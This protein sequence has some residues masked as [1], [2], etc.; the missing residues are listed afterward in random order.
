[1]RNVELQNWR[2]TYANTTIP[3]R[4]PGDIT[5]DLYRAGRIEDPYYGMNH[6]DL[7]WIA[8]TDFT[9]E[10][11]LPADEEM[12]LSE[13]VRVIFEGIDLFADIYIN[14]RFLGSTQNMFLAYEYELLPYLK[15]GGNRLQVRMKSTTKAIANGRDSSP[16]ISIF[17][18]KRF[19]VRKAQCHFGWDWA[20][21]M[22]GYGIWGRAYVQA[23]SKYRIR[24]VHY[25]TTDAGEVTLFAETD[26]NLLNIYA[27][28]SIVAIPG[29]E[30]KD[31]RL[32]FCVSRE[33]F[34]EPLWKK[35]CDLE[36]SKCFV[37]FAYENPARWWPAGYGDQPLYHYRVEL[38]RDGRICDVISGRFAFRTVHIE[39][40]P[41]QSYRMTHTLCIN[42]KE[43]FMKGSNWVPMECFSGEMRREQYERFID[44]AVQANY[45]MLRIWGGGLYETDDFYDLC[46]E[47]GIMVW[48]DLALACSD[49]PD[50]DRAWTDNFLQEIEYQ[51][52]RL[53]VH[54]SLVYWSGGNE[55]PGSFAM[56]TSK[57]DFMVNYILPGMLDQLD[58]TRPFYRQ[59]PCSYMDIGNNPSDGDC[60]WG[61]FER[62]LTD[63]VWDYRSYIAEKIPPLASEC[64]I[65][66]PCSVESFEKF[67]PKESLWPMDEVWIDRLTEN[68]HSHVKMN[69]PEREYF[70]AKE[71]YKEPESL[72]DFVKK[73]MQ[74]HAEAIRAELEIMRAHKGFCSGFM[75]WMYNDIWPQATWAVVDYYGEP[76]QAYYQMKR[77]F[78]PVLAGFFEDEKGR[79]NLFVVNDLHVPYTINVHYGVKTYD[80]SILYEDRMTVS[81]LMNAS[82]IQPVDFMCDRDDIYLFA[83]YA[84]EQGEKKV[85]YSPHF[86]MHHDFT[87]DYETEIEQA[88]DRHVKVKIHA[89]A[90]AKS[91]FVSHR[92]N[93]RF[94]YSDNYVDVELGDTVVISVSADEP[95]DKED[96][97]ITDF[98]KKIDK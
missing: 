15:K 38:H 60:H 40:R 33:P 81:E 67:L 94:T 13:S 62:C 26:Y 93:Y 84:T 85:L 56:E 31:D 80:G 3:A 18:R 53:R 11:D 27:P 24:D 28:G 96:L 4:V 10:A 44:R 54:P 63:G 29:E 64:A 8:D 5:M 88:D 9:Y 58:P 43:V 69:F 22:P 34:G 21:D 71:F 61:N 86:W 32:V 50:D 87:S 79:T 82:V 78:E 12:L 20:P 65:M 90:F 95:F 72:T 19:F 2:L 35:E 98:A 37:N 73:G 52:R 1:M 7:A 59:S 97:I 16:Y 74:V 23:G 55:R 83:E 68:P 25:R 46:D 47:K 48:Q 92:D 41:Y 51:V 75:N 45:N 89:R 57:G 42:Q 17:N 70:Y 77:S 66:G 49:V 14:D 39:E 6:R 30:K 36:G 91:V 76:K